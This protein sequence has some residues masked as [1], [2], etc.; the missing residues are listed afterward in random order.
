VRSP[1]G[2]TKAEARLWVGEH[3]VITS[4]LKRSE[5]TF[6]TTARLLQSIV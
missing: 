6:V 2:V 5:K 1:F 3:G 4:F